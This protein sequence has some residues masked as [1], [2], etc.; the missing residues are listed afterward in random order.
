[1]F[2]SKE[3]E[4]ISSLCKKY[5]HDIRNLNCCDKEMLSNIRDMSC[6]EKMYIILA[7]NDVVEHVKDSL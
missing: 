1:M 5:I 6:E 2:K 3:K 7:F 4:S